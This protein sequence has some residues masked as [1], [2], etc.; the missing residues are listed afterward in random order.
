MT[1]LADLRRQILAHY[2]IGSEWYHEYRQ[3]RDAIAEQ[4]R[5]LLAE[6]GLS[7]ERIWS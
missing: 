5:A 7:E 1:D 4:Y 3:E 2:P 6:N